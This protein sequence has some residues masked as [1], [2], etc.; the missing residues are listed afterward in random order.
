M[1]NLL[2][3]E[4]ISSRIKSENGLSFTEFTYTLL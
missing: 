1:G 2:S 3:K 4:I